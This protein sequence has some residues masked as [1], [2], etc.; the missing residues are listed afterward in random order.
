MTMTLQE[1][2]DRLE[3]QELFVDYTQAID[4]RNWDALDDVFTPDAWIDYSSTG[5]SKG[6]LP[7]TKEFL[8]KAMLLFVSF[9]H[10]VGTSKIVV[11]GDTA[12]STSILHNP[13]TLPAEGDTP[14]QTFFVGLWYH[15]KLVR[16][17]DGWRIKERVEELSYMHNVPANFTPPE[18]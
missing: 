12:T 3:I 14:P 7:S 5:G 16:T 18:L 9:Q 17:A 13:M 2:S 6:D 1:I 10:M 4:R 11:D 15:D 8:A